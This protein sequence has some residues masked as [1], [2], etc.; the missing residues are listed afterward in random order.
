VARI[1]IS[2][3]FED[4]RDCRG[5]VYDTLR[6]LRHDV[7]SMEDYTA[8]GRPPLEKCLQDVASCELFVGIYAW[9]HGYRP[10]GKRRSITE[11]ELEEAKRRNLPCL[12]F[13]LREEAPWP[14][15]FV[16]DDRS[17]IQA[18]RE[19]LK[20]DHTVEFFNDAGDLANRVGTAVANEC[21]RLADTASGDTLADPSKRQFYRE[22]L[23]KFTSELGSQIR[24]YSISSS[25][26]VLI[27]LAVFAAGVLAFGESK[28]LI[29]SFGG[30]LVGST[31]AFPLVALLSARKKK[32]LLAG[33]SNELGKDN[34]AREAVVTVQRFLEQQLST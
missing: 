34:P 22:C 11:L 29:V 23:D 5:A 30:A 1:Y 20:V 9:R 15:T 26:L 6:R 33:Y 8:S 31:T 32:A 13:L 12:I 28:S 7:I 4:L 27:G 3:T 10:P 16:D 19:R 25:S 2:S 21:A 17:T 24:F 14:T 18:L